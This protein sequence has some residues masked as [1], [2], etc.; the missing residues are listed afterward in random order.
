[1]KAGTVRVLDGEKQIAAFRRS[2]M[3]PGEMEQIQLP[4]Q[5]LQGTGG[6]LTV[7]VEEASEA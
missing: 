1:M 7:L 2:H 4:L 6:K 5:L 3:A